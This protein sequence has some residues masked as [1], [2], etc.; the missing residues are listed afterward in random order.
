MSNTFICR[1][2]EEKEIDIKATRD[3]HSCL[4]IMPVK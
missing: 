2:K 1:K 4:E 3:D